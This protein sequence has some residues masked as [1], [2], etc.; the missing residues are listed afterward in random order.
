MATGHGAA[1]PQSDDNLWRA[2]GGAPIEA[3]PLEGDV[4]A[5]VA[6][7][8]GGYAGLSAALRLAEGGAKVRLL[9]AA[10]IGHG[11]SGRNVGLVNAGL[12][13]PPDEVE[14][15]LGAE[16][17]RRLNA[18]LA[19]G[20]ALVFDLI[21]RH[22][23]ACEARRAG[24]LH[25]AHS[26]A[27]L[28]DLEKRLSQQQARGAPVEL[29]DAAETRRRTGT[30]AYRGALLDR[31]AGTIQPLGYARGV[32]RAAIA[33][34][35]VIH[36]ETPVRGW[37]HDGGRWRIETPGGTVSA[38]RMI[39]ATN[40]YRS[41]PADPHPAFTTL[42]YFQLATEPL[43]PGLGGSILAGGE[44]CWDTA[45]VM[46]SFRRDAAGRL[47]IGAIGALAGVGEAAHRAWAARKLAALFPALA[48]SRFGHAW[49]GRIA[50][51]ADHMPKVAR[52]GPGAV[53]LFGYSGRGISPGTVFGKAAAEWA[54]G[55]DEAAFPVPPG[56]LGREAFARLKAHYYE[57]GAA[58]THL[59]AARTGVHIG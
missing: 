7:I 41:E 52:L 49:F 10:A 1:R 57:A 4:E 26:A 35:A 30:R 36:E 53:A 31:R 28:E 59:V 20:P 48:G 11:G 43:P 32:A 17:G 39:V 3:S 23:I 24:T 44:G 34:G 56:P 8:G 2:T 45:M 14:A 18:I 38:G 27:G 33:A 5:D 51:P 21:E 15:V 46:T 13:T 22:G 50:M 58:L 55:G 12:W 54:I 47:I 29:L 16:T 9:E 40:A 6:V 42:N 25:L 19:A 37:R